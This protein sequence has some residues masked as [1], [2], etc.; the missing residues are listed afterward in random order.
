MV[1]VP[2]VGLKHKTGICPLSVWKSLK[3]WKSSVPTKVLEL[4]WINISDC[5]APGLIDDYDAVLG[6]MMV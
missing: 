3:F 2:T 1:M 6:G 4:W 5:R